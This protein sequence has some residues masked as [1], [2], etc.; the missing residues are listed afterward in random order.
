[1]WNVQIKP[2]GQFNFEGKMTILMKF[3]SQYSQDCGLKI[4]EPSWSQIAGSF[5]SVWLLS[6]A[7]F[8][9]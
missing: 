6:P 8:E 9:N 1:M 4:F 7:S 5:I 3:T 2:I